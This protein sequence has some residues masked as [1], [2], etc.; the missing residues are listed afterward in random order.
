[1]KA[2]LGVFAGEFVC[3][4][5]SDLLHVPEDNRTELDTEGGNLTRLDPLVAHC[6]E[7][8]LPLWDEVGGREPVKKDD[9]P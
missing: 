3:K 1:M 2:T 6:A 5:C 8:D 4:H 7:C 9:E